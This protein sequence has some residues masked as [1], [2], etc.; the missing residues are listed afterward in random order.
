MLLPFAWQRSLKFRLERSIVF[1]VA[2][3]CFRTTLGIPIQALTVG[4]IISCLSL[5]QT[6]VSGQ[7]FAAAEAGYRTDRILV[8]PK[9]AISPATF[10]SFR[11]NQKSAV[12][13]T[14]PAVGGLQVL[15][16]PADET[17]PGLI[18]KYQDSGLVEY[19]EPDYA[20]QIFSTT[21][22]DP[23]YLDHTLWGLDKIS[24]PSA[25]DVLTSA[26]NMI[27]TLEAIPR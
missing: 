24:A 27:L 19:A 13:Q 6:D 4:W 2:P 5:A 10:A 25:W 18:K 26:S 8:K 17:V 3:R 1:S 15:S 11:T 22:N 21:P 9:A 7:G 23:R 14:F 12:L 20:A 16:V